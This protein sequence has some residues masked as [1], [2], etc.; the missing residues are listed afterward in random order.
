MAGAGAG[1]GAD[2]KIHLYRIPSINPYPMRILKIDNICIDENHNLMRA[3][4]V[5]LSGACA[6]EEETQSLS[7]SEKT[8]LDELFEVYK[9]YINAK[10]A[11]E[12]AAAAFW[13]TE[14][15]QKM[16]KILC[17]HP[18]LHDRPPLYEKVKILETYLSSLALEIKNRH[19]DISG[20]NYIVASYTLIMYETQEIPDTFN[21]FV[22]HTF[23]M[24]VYEEI[25]KLWTNK[26][27][28]NRKKIVQC[29]YVFGHVLPP[30]R[31]ADVSAASGSATR[32][33]K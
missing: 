32:G 12:T 9:T 14:S 26:M 18:K 21:D 11:Y 7:K 13:K 19:V 31:L 3:H 27:V 33:V 8:N 17:P 6:V 23:T 2:E 28:Q 4:A 25:P 10:K 20:Y 15:G 22:L 5:D 30:Y 1:A 24:R 29:V 16:E